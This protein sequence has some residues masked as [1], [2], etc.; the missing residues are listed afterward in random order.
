MSGIQVMR[1]ETRKTLDNDLIRYV[2]GASRPAATRAVVDPVVV[3]EDGAG[4]AKAVVTAHRAAPRKGG[5]PPQ[6][7]I[8]FL[9]AG[10]PGCGAEGGV[11]R[12][13]GTGV[14]A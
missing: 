7:A 1:F 8:E 14:G 9:L 6:E 3:L 2:T 13:T 4:A 11:G 10:P 5:R 12:G